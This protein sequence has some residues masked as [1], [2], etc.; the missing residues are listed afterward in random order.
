MK[1]KL[2]ALVFGLA[3]GGLVFAATSDA[4]RIKARLNQL[5]PEVKVDKV[6]PAEAPGMFEVVSGRHVFY[7]DASARYVFEGSLIDIE[8]K[9]NLT[10]ARTERLNRV[11]F[12]TL[13]LSDAIVSVKGNGKRKMAIFS[14]PDCPYC[15]KL[16]VQLASVDNVT[17]YTFLF[18]IAQLHSNATERAISVWCS[19]DR[20]KAWGIAMKG[21]SLPS[22]HCDT[23]VDRNI[24]LGNKLGVN[25]T[26]TMIFADGRRVPGLIPAAQIETLLN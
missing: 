3:G 19:P 14:D 6:T 5:A 12:N 18:P 17:I 22:L 26:P 20:V 1:K 23:P 16:E 4:D 13:P 2:I 11:D 21:G 8:R 7:T 15:R 9:V 10:E 24:A 25:G